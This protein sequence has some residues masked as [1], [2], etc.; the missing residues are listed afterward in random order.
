M[1]VYAH[2]R[3][4]HKICTAAREFCCMMCALRRLQYF[5]RGMCRLW[6]REHATLR[7][8]F[9]VPDSSACLRWAQP[10]CLL[11]SGGQRILYFLS[12]CSAEHS[13][14]EHRFERQE[15]SRQFLRD[16]FRE[17]R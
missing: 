8:F 15:V 12:N 9:D 10:V 7:T 2:K 17:F 3:R 6:R 5:V 1:L 13:T 16:E 4:V 14:R 11:T